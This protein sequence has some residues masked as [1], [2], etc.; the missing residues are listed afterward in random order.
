MN[1]DEL[2]ILFDEDEMSI[3]GPSKD[4]LYKMYGIFLTHFHKTPLQ[5]RGKKV[6]FNTNSSK[7][8]LFK[9]KVQGF[10]HLITRENK[11]NDKRQYDRDRANRMHWV[12]PILENWENP[13]VSYF[14]Q[15]NKDGEL[16]YFYWLQAH[17]FVVI[18]RELNPDLLLVTAYC[19]DAYQV[20]QFRK[21]L[22]EFR[23]K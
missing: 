3:D 22:S 17:S 12:K 7:H 2:E 6:V 15:H 16:Q 10:V 18:L 20:S 1:F 23:K 11:Y 4:Q 14:E 9:G 13:K 19:V 21:Q 8:P 5:H